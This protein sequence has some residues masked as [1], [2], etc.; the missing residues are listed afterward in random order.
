[1]PELLTDDV[2]LQAKLREHPGLRWKAVNV[3]RHREQRDDGAE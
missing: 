1:M 3:R 2:A